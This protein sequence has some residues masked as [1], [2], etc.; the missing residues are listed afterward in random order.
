MNRV[1][2]P[3]SE[4]SYPDPNPGNC[5]PLS[6]LITDEAD[7]KFAT[8]SLLAKFSTAGEIQLRPFSLTNYACLVCGTQTHCGHFI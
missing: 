8:C 3:G 6:A 2:G 4:I 1:L 5:Y 7:E